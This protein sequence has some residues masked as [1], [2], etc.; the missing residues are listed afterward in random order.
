MSEKATITLVSGNGSAG[1]TK[2]GPISAGSGVLH[3]LGFV[4][5]SISAA[6]EGFAASMSAH[7]DGRIT[8]D[9]VQGVRVAFFRPADARNPVVE[10]VEPASEA[11]PVSHF[12][13]KRGGGLH[14]MCYEVKDL[15]STLREAKGAGFG[16][17]APPTPAVA[18]EGRRIAWINR[19]RLLMELL[20]RD[21]E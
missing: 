5:P 4:V 12:L 10:L 14:H 18:F 2:G 3:H 15:D 7:W 6:A 13:K 21:D 11:S 1:H 8:Y 19:N 20:E 16:V 17:V 9:P